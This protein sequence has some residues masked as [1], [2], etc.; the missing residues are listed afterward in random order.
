MGE[1]RIRKVQG[2]E[3]GGFDDTCYIFFESGRFEHPIMVMR[4]Y[5]LVAVLKEAGLKVSTENK[6][7]GK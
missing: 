5:D 4:E 6:E 7:K 3:A 2:T 1:I